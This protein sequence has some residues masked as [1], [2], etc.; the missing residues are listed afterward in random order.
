MYT[1]EIENYKGRGIA[2][3]VNQN[4]VSSEIEIKDDVIESIWCQINLKGRD[5]RI[6]GCIYRSPNSPV[7]SYKKYW[8]IVIQK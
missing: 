5:K 7:D 2:I 1:H 4:L 6:I 8:R 3:Y